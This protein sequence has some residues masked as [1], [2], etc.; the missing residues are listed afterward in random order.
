M[1]H[2]TKKSVKV[3]KSELSSIKKFFNDNNG[4]RGECE[5]GK[6]A[7]YATIWRFLDSGKMRPDKIIALRKF[8]QEYEPATI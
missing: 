1:M 7:S 8:I 4:A 2:S 6:I 5:R 3:S